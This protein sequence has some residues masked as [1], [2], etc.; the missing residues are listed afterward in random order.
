[1]S[2]ELN[3]DY[4]RELYF[5]FDKNVPYI[6]KCGVELEIHPVYLENSL[7]FNSSYE[8]LD[9]DKNSLN[10]PEIISMSYLK[11]LFK[12]KIS[13]KHSR[14]QLFNICNL[15]LGLNKPYIQLDEKG[16]AV[17]Y[18][19]DDNN[20]IILFI[21]QKEFE[22]I[23]RI[24]LYQN[25]PD[26]DDNYINPDLKKAMQEQDELLSKNIVL[27]SLERKINI[28]TSHTG[29]TQKEQFNMTLR[30]H[31]LLFKE[32]VGEVNFQATKA[33]SLYAGQKD[34]VQ[35]I[36]QQKKGKFDDYVTSVENY[37]KSFGGDGNILSS[38]NENIKNLIKDIK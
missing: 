29:I 30:S 27:P 8:I 7:L 9:I 3:F 18:E 10:D 2:A 6:L 35:W 26:Y 37:N 21:T 23:R 15:C 19:L 34:A 16:K 33:I 24:I 32:V 11:F 28:I 31:S 25:I 1:M 38:T 17:L 20:N 14:Q 4:L 36:Y 13:D 12:K 5:V 22:D